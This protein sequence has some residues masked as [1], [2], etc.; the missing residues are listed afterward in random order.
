MTFSDPSARREV[1]EFLQEHQRVIAQVPM[2]R[3]L[4]LFRSPAYRRYCQEQRKLLAEL[5]RQ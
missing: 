3:R 1:G 5:N 2:E 4:A